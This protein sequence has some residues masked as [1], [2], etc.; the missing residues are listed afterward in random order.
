MTGRKY[1]D[2]YHRL[3]AN[4][5]EDEDGCWIWTGQTRRGYPRM[6]MRV[7]GR[8][9]PIQVAAHR[10]MLEEWT[11]FYFPFDEGG[12]YRCFK[13]LCIRPHCLRVETKAENLSG[14]RG[15][16]EAKGRWIPVL[17]PTPARIE[18]E[19]IDAALEQAP[20]LSL[21]GDPIPF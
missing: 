11:G 17:F 15:Y 13:P 12:H 8:R 6:S 21:P 3:V 19:E 7:P 5:V 10:V 9:S 4:T 2:N 20:G 18:A 14:R 1:I 16:A